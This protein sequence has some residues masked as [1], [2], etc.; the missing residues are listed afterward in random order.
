MREKQKELDEKGIEQKTKDG[1]LKRRFREVACVTAI[2]G[3]VTR[4]VNGLNDSHSIARKV[5]AE[6]SQAESSA[7]SLR[8]SLVASEGTSDALNTKLNSQS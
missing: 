4:L 6:L 2:R 3:Q 5:V 8:T 7:T 1:E